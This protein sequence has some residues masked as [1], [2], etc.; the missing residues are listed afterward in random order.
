MNGI[1][2]VIFHLSVTL[3]CKFLQL[4]WY[5]VVKFCKMDNLIISLQ[6][7]WWN[8]RSYTLPVW[9]ALNYSLLEH[10]SYIEV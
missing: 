9:V 4:Q 5:S 10:I 8:L 2:Y 1:T 6:K 7:D 3:W